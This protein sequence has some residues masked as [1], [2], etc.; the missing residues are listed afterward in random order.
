MRRSD[1]LKS[2]WSHQSL[3]SFRQVYLSGQWFYCNSGS[4][5][6]RPKFLHTNIQS[7]GVSVTR[8]LPEQCGSLTMSPGSSIFIR[9]LPR[10]SGACAGRLKDLTA[11]GYRDSLG[12]A[13]SP[14]YR[15]ADLH[16]LPIS[17]QKKCSARMTVLRGLTT[18]IDVIKINIHRHKRESPNIRPLIFQ[19]SRK[20]YRANQTREFI[21]VGLALINKQ[22]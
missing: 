9:R 6:W 11:S 10:P 13:D 5:E 18:L 8:A 3:N 15:I 2:Q 1:K 17:G 21:D 20:R 4:G 7:G 14:N 19:T 12:A 16:P 22:S